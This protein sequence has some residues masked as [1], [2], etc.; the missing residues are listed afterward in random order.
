[1]VMQLLILLV[2]N[3]PPQLKD[4]Q[5]LITPVY[6]AY[7]RVIGTLLGI[8]Q[9]VL[10]ATE[11]GYP[12][13]LPWCCNKLLGKWL[14]TDTKASWKKIIQAINSPAVAALITHNKTAVVDPQQGNYLLSSHTLL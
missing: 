4:L 3:S 13:N 11:G 10:D 5:N 7:W 8:Q 6:A 14:D 12:T 9:G 2:L 1:M